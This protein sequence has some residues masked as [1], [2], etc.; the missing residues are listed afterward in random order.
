MRQERCTRYELRLKANTGETGKVYKG[1][2]V[3]ENSY[4]ETHVE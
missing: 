2:V 4:S 1:R 3:M